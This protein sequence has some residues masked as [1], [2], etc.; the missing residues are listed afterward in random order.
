MLYVHG[1]HTLEGNT[2][3]FALACKGSNI[4]ASLMVPAVT[5]LWSV[6]VLQ[7]NVQAEVVSQLAKL[8]GHYV[9]CMAHVTCS[10]WACMK[11]HLQKTYVPLFCTVM[12]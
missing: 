12:H 3:I 6:A 4:H 5:L 9:P 11:E 8:I 10:M 1:E 7:T 2:T